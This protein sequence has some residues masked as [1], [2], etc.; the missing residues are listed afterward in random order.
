M[1]RVGFSHESST[2][3]R[4]SDVVDRRLAELLLSPPM[5]AAT[6]PVVALV[7]LLDLFFPHRLR[8]LR[9]SG[10]RFA[11]LFHIALG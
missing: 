4:S 9:P 3:R 8:L 6:R 10:Q 2:R 1:C 5:L 7:Y 11:R